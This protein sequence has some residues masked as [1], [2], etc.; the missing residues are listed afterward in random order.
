MT[1][2]LP[3]AGKIC[4]FLRG[5]MM[6]K[7]ILSAG[8]IQLILSAVLVVISVMF[9]KTAKEAE[10]VEKQLA[11]NCFALHRA[12]A[13][14]EVTFNGSSEV[15][16]RISL[17]LNRLPE[18][19]KLPGVVGF[20][21]SRKQEKQLNK[22]LEDLGKTCRQT[23]GVLNNYHTKTAP[24]VV[25]ALQETSRTLDLTGA[26]IRDRKPCTGISS[27]VLL[28]GITFAVICFFNG[29]FLIVLS[30]AKKELNGKAG[31]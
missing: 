21:L 18:N 8:V 29:V 10:V 4:L 15:I 23:A 11:E 12:L 16:E 31:D 1:L 26:L 5:I 17:Q 25:R 13:N 14:S 28:L 7:F 9:Q 2:C 24:E 19:L 3:E 6:K 27:Y 30:C 20:I 22:Q